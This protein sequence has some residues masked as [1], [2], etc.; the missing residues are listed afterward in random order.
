MGL[1]NVKVFGLGGTSKLS[2]LCTR[3]ALADLAFLC[4]NLFAAVFVESHCQAFPRVSMSPMRATNKC[5]AFSDLSSA[6]VNKG[7]R[8]VRCQHFTQNPFCWNRT[9]SLTEYLSCPRFE[10]HQ[11]GQCV[12]AVA[13]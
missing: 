12:W 1:G 2:A 7:R 8:L 10:G 13:E 4:R 9:V 3:T 11:G 6:I 5:Q